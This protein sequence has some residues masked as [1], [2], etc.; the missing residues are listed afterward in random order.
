MTE[1]QARRLWDSARTVPP[2][3]QMVEIGSFRGRSA[4]VMASALADGARLVAIDPHA[5]GDRGPQEIEAEAARGEED[6][7]RFTAN[8][9]AAGVADRVRHVRKMSS[10]AL[11]SVD[12]EID[13]LYVD[14][15]HRFGPAR[16]DLVRWGAR[17]REGGTMLVHDSFSAIGL[18]LAMLASLSFGGRWRYVGRSG[19]LAEYRRESLGSGARVA[20]AGRQL[21]Q[22]P[23]FARNVLLKVAIV[24]RLRPLQRLLGSRDGAWPY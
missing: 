17:V 15:A 2:G 4:I 19:S 1:A 3:G 13:V 11:G 8:L 23:W 7:R 21:A 6:N 18:T 9:S 24:A 16:D 20:S 14:G 12:G 22:L 10:D 5:G